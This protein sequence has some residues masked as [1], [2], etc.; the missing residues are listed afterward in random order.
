MNENNANIIND[1]NNVLSLDNT[2]ESNEQA[3]SVQEQILLQAQAPYYYDY[4][5]EKTLENHQTII[6]NRSII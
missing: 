2:I 1:S 5:G 6:Q 3:N 4:Y